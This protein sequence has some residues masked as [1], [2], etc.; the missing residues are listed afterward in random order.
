MIH[1]H[2]PH[3]E[4]PGLVTLGTREACYPLS[5]QRQCPGFSSL[6]DGFRM[7]PQEELR[8]CHPTTPCGELW[9]MSQRPFPQRVS[10]GRQLQ[11]CSLEF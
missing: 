2:Y 6:G 1:A 11:M 9:A 5:L 8:I 7:L 4:M 10:L 3:S